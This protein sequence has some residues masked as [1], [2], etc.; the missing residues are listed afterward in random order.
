MQRT[1]AL[2]DLA[3]LTARPIAHRGLHDAKRGIVENSASAFAAAIEADY[4]IECDLQLSR[5]GEAVVFHDETLDRLMEAGGLVAAHSVA[6]LKAMAFR[7]GSDRIQ[8]LGEFLAQ[9]RG[10]APLVI[11]LKSPWN[12]NE[13]LVRRAIAVVRGYHG[14]FALMSFDPKAVELVR[15]IAPDVARG[16]VADQTTHSDYDSLP[17]A[18]RSR[19]RELAH[20]PETEP[21]FISYHFRDL[22]FPPVTRFRQTRRP[23]ITWT[24]RSR[25]DAATARRYSDQITFEGFRA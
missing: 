23:V 5:D 7:E 9:V 6:E 12:G 25:Q 3:W 13:A 1:S 24:I 10:R 15:R 22:P 21:D 19:L 16:I 11:E 17:A 8:T 18:E 4:A 2:P 14:P 20:L